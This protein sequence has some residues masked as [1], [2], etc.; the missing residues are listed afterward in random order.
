MKVT[1]GLQAVI[2]LPVENSRLNLRLQS[3]LTAGSG[4]SGRPVFVPPLAIKS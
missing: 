3:G 4:D 2:T 1:A